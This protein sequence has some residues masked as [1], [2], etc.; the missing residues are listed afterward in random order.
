MN[1]LDQL[2]GELS[3]EGRTDS[4]GRFTLKLE[5][6]LELLS[7][8]RRR[9]PEGYVL[10]VV[11]AA[12][13]GGAPWLDV[14]LLNGR[15]VF[16]Y[17]G[18]LLSAAERDWFLQAPLL[19][20]APVH[21]RE[22]ALAL[23]SAAAMPGAEVKLR[24]EAGVVLRRGHM[25][26]GPTGNRN[27]LEVVTRRSW[28]WSGRARGPEL[29]LLERYCRHCSV[30]LTVNG[31]PFG[32]VGPPA[33]ACLEL[34]PEGAR[35]LPPS[36]EAAYRNWREFPWRGWI[37]LGVDLG[38]PTALCLR[39]HG[40]LVPV[41]REL[42][43][44]CQVLVEADLPCDLE[45]KPV[46]GQELA[47]LLEEL[48]PN[49]AM[50]A[51]EVVWQELGP[52]E[53]RQQLLK[54]LLRLAPGRVDELRVLGDFTLRE[55]E[56]A[57]EER[58]FLTVVGEEGEYPDC[59]GPVLVLTDLLRPAL[60]ERF[61][62]LLRLDHLRGVEVGPGLPEGNYLVRVPLPLEESPGELGLTWTPREQ[63]MV[64][65][66][67][68]AVPGGASILAYRALFARKNLRLQAISDHAL[69][70][71]AASRQV[72]AP[73]ELVSL[74][75]G[76]WPHD[77]LPRDVLAETRPTDPWVAARLPHIYT[78]ILGATGEVARVLRRKR[79]KSSW[80]LL[81][82]TAFDAGRVLR[83]ARIRE[84]WAELRAQILNVAAQEAWRYKLGP[85]TTDC[86]LLALS[87]TPCQAQEALRQADI[88]TASLR[89]N[90]ARQTHRETQ[91]ELDARC[92][93]R[94]GAPTFVMRAT[95]HAWRGL[96]ELAALDVAAALEHNP[97]CYWARTLQGQ[98]HLTRGQH[99][100]ARQAFEQAAARRL[101]G[102]EAQ[103][104]LGWC[105][106]LE[107]HWTSARQH[108]SGF[109]GLLAMLCLEE[110]D[111]ARS[112]LL[113]EQAL[114]RDP[115][116]LPALFTRAQ[117]LERLRR[118]ADKAYAAYTEAQELFP[119]DPWWR[120][121]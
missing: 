78:G 101:D 106:Y 116:E 3:G 47:R 82:S 10:H 114:K 63:A 4:R 37:A 46:E 84:D 26:P 121:R 77:Q 67:A 13:S 28:W 49:L 120:R 38:F 62:N 93:A 54:G 89:H 109:P 59:W 65:A 11:A 102:P 34:G 119:V 16:V 30:P 7:R 42:P 56:Q 1:E 44:P 74:V 6:A 33:V 29:G 32:F 43:L 12:V 61:P 111:L 70:Q 66:P 83:P 117:T 57:Y 14:R 115:Y 92:E 99:A 45:G 27:E 90:V 71:L 86:L 25:E 2:L 80:D 51:F 104:G 118:D 22:L 48:R 15:A 17:E 105:D 91:A 31:T 9:E 88:S 41:E 87:E 97:R 76:H 20:D 36:M 5:R 52:L 35:D 39:P 19:P 79:L 8:L 98:L 24:S 58:G 53:L 113:A 60:G 69:L 21:L 112:L 103:H 110:G 50:L 75:W 23:M 95:F 108:W 40:V 73:E 64:L 72:P 55:L 81:G 85:I 94:P 18:Q 100:E 68:S 96:L 107:G